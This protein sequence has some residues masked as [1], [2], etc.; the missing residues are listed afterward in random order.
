VE[1]HIWHGRRAAYQWRY[2]DAIT[3]FGN[4]IERFPEEAR[5][6]RHRGHRY[7]TVRKFERAQ[8]DFERAAALI[9]GTD[10]MVEPDGAPNA[11]GIPVSSLHTNI[12]Y[13][14]GLTYYLQGEF[15][16]AAQSFQKCLDASTNN[17]MMIAA[18]DWLYMSLRRAG[19]HDS[20]ERVL[21]SIEE[22]LELLEN[23]SYY[24]RLLMY[25]GLL[26]ADSLLATGAQEADRELTIATQGYGVGNWYLYNGDTT[27]AMSIFDD[28]LQGKYWAAFGY[29]AA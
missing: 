26:D 8:E 11:A 27:R 28:V 10:D 17:D 9:E 3:I 14:L 22:G 18:S 13:H 23:H 20:A 16:A 15:A 1:T 24:K 25:K 19:Q 21:D 4:G 2:R 29:I 7:I 6:Y 5:L 12:W